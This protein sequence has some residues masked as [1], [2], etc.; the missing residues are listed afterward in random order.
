MNNTDKIII[1]CDGS[2]R[3]NPGPG[4]WG[5]IVSE[6]GGVIE[7]G[8]GEKHTTNN[9]MELQ[10]AIHALRSVKDPEREIIVNTDSAYVIGGMTEWIF[11]WQKNNW[12]TSAKKPV[13]NQDLWEELAETALG[14]KIAWKHVAGHAGIPGNERCDAIATG[15]A[16]GKPPKLFSGKSSDYAITLS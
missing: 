11:S 1:F 8:G 9:R 10:G 4:G 3:G 6:D 15:F 5:A 14:K 13:L 2:S 16:D 7:L 12:R